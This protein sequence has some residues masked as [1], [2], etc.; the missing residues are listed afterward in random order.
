[1]CNVMSSAIRK[2]RKEIL[3]NIKGSLD[4]SINKIDGRVGGSEKN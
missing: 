4:Y 2:V 1:M 3:D